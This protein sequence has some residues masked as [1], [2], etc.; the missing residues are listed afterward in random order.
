M[1]LQLRW[2]L[3]KHNPPPPVL[4]S[5]TGESMQSLGDKMWQ[6]KR[7]NRYIEIKRTEGQFKAKIGKLLSDI[8]WHMTMLLTS[9]RRFEDCEIW[10]VI[11]KASQYKNTKKTKTKQ[12]AGLWDTLRLH[13][14]A[15]ETVVT[16]TNNVGSRL[17]DCGPSGARVGMAVGWRVCGTSQITVWYVARTVLFFELSHHTTLYPTIKSWSICR[18]PSLPTEI[19]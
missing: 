8:R 17:T 11:Q 1:N 19:F 18:R 12:N 5:S 3:Q 6:N 14:Q 10:I 16:W 15:L 2:D 7:Q 4:R 9:K 13:G